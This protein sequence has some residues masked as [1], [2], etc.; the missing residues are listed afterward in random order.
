MKA[1]K[2]RRIALVTTTAGFL[3]GAALLNGGA[4]HSIGGLCNGQPASATWLDASGQYGPALIDGTDHD[5]TIIGSDGDDHI[6]AGG[7]DDVVCGAAGHNHIHG[8][9]GDDALIGSSD[10]DH[11]DGGH[12]HDTVVGYGGHDTVAGGPGND[13]L[14]GGDGD[15][16]MIS[17]DAGHDHGDEGGHGEEGGHDHEGEGGHDHEGEGGHDHGHDG[18]VRTESEIDKVSAG[19]GFDVCLFSAGDEL[20][21]CEY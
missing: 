14:V 16:V 15:D 20:S 21:N 10:H 4:A 2:A 5:D 13:F 3:A 18:P 1:L 19:D 11:L 7:G 17:T 9:D 6:D 12:G 8:G